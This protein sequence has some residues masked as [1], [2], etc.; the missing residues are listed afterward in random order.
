MRMISALGV[1]VL[2]AAMCGPYGASMAADHDKA[3]AHGRYLIKISGCND[4]HT[5]GYGPSGG[6]VP[7]DQLLVGQGFVFVGPWGTSYPV[8]LRLFVQPLTVEEWIRHARTT[9]SLP[10]MPWYSLRDMS[11]YDL[12]SIYYY[13]RSLGP[14]GKPAPA[15]LPPGQ[16]PPPPYM[17]LMLPAPVPAAGGASR[18]G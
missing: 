1:M 6:H 16:K 2:A 5:P 4:C 11:D 8:N 12:A 15:A 10:P 18:T 3:I 17:E 7:Q 9:Q 13:I 14:A